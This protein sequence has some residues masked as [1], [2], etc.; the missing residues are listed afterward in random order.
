MGSTNP[1]I[2][3]VIVTWN[4]MKW[5]KECLE[6]IRKS[7]IHASTVIID[8]GST[9]STCEFIKKNYPEIKLLETGKNLG[10]GQANNVGI[11]YAFDNGADYVY[12]LNQ[13]AYVYPDMFEK[14]LAVSE[15][16]AHADLGILSPLH[17]HGYRTRLDSQFKEYLK[18]IGTDFLEDCTMGEPQE[19][20]HV[21]CVPAAGWFIPKA[22]LERIGGFDPIFFHYGEDH[23]YAQ[24]VKYHGLKVGV[25]PAAKMVHDRDGFGNETM[26]KKGVVMRNLET[27]VYLNINNSLGR[28]LYMFF[29]KYF[30]FVVY[31]GK[32]IARG[33]GRL[34]LQQIAAIGKS[35]V[36]IPKYCKNRKANKKQGMLWLQRKEIVELAGKI[37]KNG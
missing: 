17:V 13:D 12:L 31:S 33:N 32:E 14:L 1:K 24:R 34:V 10:F 4:G 21:D 2:F 9:D 26:A 27:E 28:Q 18:S 6:S 15:N 19:V 29:N 37:G 36:R 20:Y 11:R 30:F 5:M 7:T 23:H 22:T 3:I 8:N 25:V 16:P 35:I